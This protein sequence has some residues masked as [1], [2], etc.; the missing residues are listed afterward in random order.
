MR[1]HL[2]SLFAL[3]LLALA[4]PLQAQFRSEMRT[5]DKE[6]ELKAYNLAI[7][8]YKRALAQRPTD[9][10]AL[11][12]IADSYRMLNQIQTAHT[13]YTQAVRERQVKPNTILE[14]AHVLKSLS[15]YEEAKQ[16]YLLYARDHDK[17]VGDHFAQSC[18]FA[19][20]QANADAGFRVQASSINSPVSDFGPSMPSPGQLVFNSGRTASGQSFDGQAK[21]KPYVAAV[22]P[23]GNLQQAF[24]LQTGY[25]DAAGN[26]GPVSYTPDGRQVIFTRNNFNT[27]TR[28]IPEA[29]IVLNLMIADVN[30]NGTWVNPRPLPF[31]GTD[32][33]TGFG[34][35]SPDG[36]AIYFAS[37]RKEGYGGFDIYRA[38]RQGQSWENIPENLGTV[39]NSV[40]HEITPFFDG[41][42]L[43]FSSDWH[44]GL[45]AYD[46]FR[47][48]VVN[49][50]PTTLYHMGKGINSD[51]DDLGFIYDPVTN[52]GYVV[53]NRIGG[54]GMEDIYRVGR[55]NANKVLLVQSA[56]DGSFI[57]NASLDFTACGGQ[58]YAT[59]MGGRY[60]MQS[61]DGLTCDI[62]VSAQ[63]F[64]SVRIPVQGMAPDAQNV[65]RVTLSPVGSGTNPNI[66]G[67]TPPGSYRGVV[68]DAQT[69]AVIPG[70]T[71][72]I[73]QRT[74]GATATVQTAADGTYLLGLD[75]YNTYDL[76]ISAPGYESVR[77]PVTNNDGSDPY[78]LGNMALLPVQGGG[79]NPPAG[80]G[81]FVQTT[82]F[83][84]QLASLSKQPD[85]SKFASLSNLGRVYDV[86]TGGSY[87]VRIGVFATRAEAEIAA[88]KAKT[89]GY[90]GAFI[91]AD[92]GN[93]AFAK[94]GGQ[95]T[96]PPAGGSFPPA[97]N[98]AGKFKVQ[99][100]AF[101]KP[102]N[103]DRN[104]AMQMG[105]IEMIKKGNLTVF[106]IGGINSLADAR[107]V[108][109]R[110]T[111]LGYTG[112]FVLEDV[113]GQLVKV[114]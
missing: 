97:T 59:D 9:V 34:T 67:T 39:V 73:T 111:Q 84:V 7:E 13:Y 96:N 57:P 63:G 92:S 41:A 18:D 4:L 99:L 83:A 24:E 64:Q 86:N 79:T 89:G 60:V 71:V 49:S 15:R 50:R 77:Y 44:H 56:Q 103:F 10:E 26:V 23:D 48:E 51:R 16:W 76:V 107:S 20:A 90:P 22:G 100:G 72:F 29:G 55:A 14:H 3:L 38:K 105:N 46:V 28:M 88:A 80:G 27:G 108:Q 8:S 74:T 19:M 2:S 68:T 25:T 110:A 54:S 45:G 93:S 36:N 32:Y 95:G 104:A 1:N 75:P 52:S 61:T 82:G 70:A 33:S 91:V 53:S 40:G 62:I 109:A 35:F 11:S 58:V 94:A 78:L 66:G 85:L 5:A 102:E 31:N 98:T 87:K 43:F 37:N 6:Y 42:S 69:G 12:R 114:K 17:V 81:T 65:V 106:M 21:N 30:Q 112:A 113:N 101:S 47:A